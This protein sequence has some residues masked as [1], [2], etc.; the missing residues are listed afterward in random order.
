MKLNKLII[1]N[2]SKNKIKD[3][4]VFQDMD[5]SN[6]EGLYLQDKKIQDIKVLLKTSLSKIKSLSIENND[7]NK[8]LPQFKEFLN[9]FN[10]VLLNGLSIEEFNRNYECNIS[11]KSK[12]ITFADSHL[13]DKLIKDFS[14]INKKFE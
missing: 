4:E 3:I 11:L 1:F 8:E 6:L 13:G 12:S 7:I 5:L 2:A 10:N 14:V 9:K